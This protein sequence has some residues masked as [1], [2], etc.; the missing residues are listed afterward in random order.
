MIINKNPLVRLGSGDR[1]F[2]TDGNI[3]NLV[4]RYKLV[5]DNYQVNFY[6]DG[7]TNKKVVDMHLSEILR[8]INK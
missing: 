7:I 2:D 1:F 6:L 5:Y 4:G 3:N 8:V